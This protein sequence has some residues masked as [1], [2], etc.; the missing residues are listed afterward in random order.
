MFNT[1]HKK[2]SQGFGERYCGV[3]LVLGLVIVTIAFIAFMNGAN[4]I[5]LITS[6]I[7]FV[8]LF[9]LSVVSLCSKETWKKPDLLNIYFSIASVVVFGIAVFLCILN[10]VLIFENSN[11]SFL[12]QIHQECI[13]TSLYQEYINPTPPL[14]VDTSCVNIS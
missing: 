10:F 3:F 4:L 1:T 6:T 9:V 2:T 5:G 11:V 7:V 14:E 8:G 13:N 12:E